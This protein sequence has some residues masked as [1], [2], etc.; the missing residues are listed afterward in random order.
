MNSNY[1]PPVVLNSEDGQSYFC[2]VT[3]DLEKQTDKSMHIY[4]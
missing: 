4:N 3:K 1:D 2:S